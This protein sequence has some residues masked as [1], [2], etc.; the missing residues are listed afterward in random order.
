MC[1]D[2]LVLAHGFAFDRAQVEERITEL[3][4]LYESREAEVDDL[5]EILKVA[6][7]QI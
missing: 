5:P 3:G 1:L 6:M 4:L 7:P 2:G